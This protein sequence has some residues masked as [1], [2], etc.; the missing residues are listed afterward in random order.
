MS[1]ANPEQS[2]PGSSDSDPTVPAPMTDTGKRGYYRVIS[3]ILVSAAVAVGF[4]SGGAALAGADPNPFGTLGNSGQETAPPGSPGQREEV[5]RGIGDG[6][7]AS[8]PGLPHR[9]GP[10]SPDG[11]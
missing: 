10:G 2:A 3:R 7:S 6:L 5:D 9:P 1:I 8:L 4:C 11:L